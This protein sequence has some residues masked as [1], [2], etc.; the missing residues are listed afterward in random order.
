MR[1]QG[2]SPIEPGSTFVPEH[3]AMTPHI[4]PVHFIAIDAVD[5]V[6]MICEEEVLEMEGLEPDGSDWRTR[7]A[8][9]W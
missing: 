2:Y 9:M 4:E 6:E 3:H 7:V 5:A 1:D 8:I